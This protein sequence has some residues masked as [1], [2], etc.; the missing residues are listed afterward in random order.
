VIQEGIVWEMVWVIGK[1][2]LGKRLVIG[3]MGDLMKKTHKS[4]DTV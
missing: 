3:G 1:T 2:S 4:D